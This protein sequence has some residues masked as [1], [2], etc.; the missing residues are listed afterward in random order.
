MLKF[1]LVMKICSVV[2][3]DCLPEKLV[4][5]HDSWYNCAKKGSLETIELMELIGE[6]LINQNKLFIS[7]TCKTHNEV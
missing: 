6:D 7:F 1:V 5:F 3:G 2:H 4:S